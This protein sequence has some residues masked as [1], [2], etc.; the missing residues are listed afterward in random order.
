[1]G[2]LIRFGVSMPEALLKQFDRLI[3]EKGYRNRSEAVRDLIRTAL[4]E[5]RWKSDEAVVAGTLTLIYDHHARELTRQL[6][7]LQHDQHQMI[8]SNLHVHLDEHNC[9]EVIVIRG[10]A[11]EVK[12]MADRLKSIRGVKHGQLSITS[13]G[14]DLE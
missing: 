5:E 8:I 4:V 14:A 3:A 1:M 2:E 13:T 11:G 6:N 9:L 7:R 10:R 12:E